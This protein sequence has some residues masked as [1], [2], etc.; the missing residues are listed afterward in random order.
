MYKAKSGK[1]MEVDQVDLNGCHV[2]RFKSMSAAATELGISQQMISKCAR[3]LCKSYK[4]Y[5]WLKV[6][7]DTDHNEIWIE[8]PT[9]PITCSD[10][11][12]IK[13]RGII[14]A[15]HLRDGYLRVGINYKIYS[16]HRLIAETFL[17]PEE[18]KIQVNHINHNRTDN[19]LI[20]LE[21]CTP[22]YNSQ[23]RRKTYLD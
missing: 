14:L 17:E 18:D 8:H 15:G 9:L 5:K 4:G 21:W 22:T 1:R 2:K 10:Q 3:G 11:G 19:R 16:A 13:S 7:D 12:R 6:V 23:N 20:N